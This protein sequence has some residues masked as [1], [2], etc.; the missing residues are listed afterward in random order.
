MNYLT[1]VN[2]A[3]EIKNCYYENLKLVECKDIFGNNIKVEKVTYD[4]YIK[5]KKN[6]EIMGIFV[7]IS[8]AYRSIEQQQEII[9]EYTIKYGLNYVKKYVAPIKT[10]EHHTGLA[11][12]L[13]LVVNGKKCSNNEEAFMHEDIYLETHKYLSEFGFILRYPKGKENITGYDYEP[14]H[15]RYVGKEAAELIYKNDLTLEEYV[16]RYICK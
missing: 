2:K 3:N 13:A 9:D 4:A 6:L 7:E 8:S 5:L 16:F 1:I 12:D 11:L 10:S 14:W 15:I